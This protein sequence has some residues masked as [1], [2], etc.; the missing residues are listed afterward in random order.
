MVN[1][2]NWC[3]PAKQAEAAKSL[4]GQGVDVITQHQDCTST[5]IKATEAAGA[6]TVGYH[7]DASSARPEGLGHRL[8]SGTGATSTP[9]S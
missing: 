5:I 9:T 3:D 6:M 1:T 2:S 4:L 8:A 7:A